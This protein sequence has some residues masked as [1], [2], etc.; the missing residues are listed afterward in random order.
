MF[1]VAEVLSG[2]ENKRFLHD[3]FK[4]RLSPQQL[5]DVTYPPASIGQQSARTRHANAMIIILS[6]YQS[7]G[8]P[9]FE[10]PS[11]SWVETQADNC[12]QAL[13][14]W[15]DLPNVRTLPASKDRAL[16]S[17]LY[18]ACAFVL[19]IAS[20]QLHWLYAFN[21]DLW[22]LVESKMEKHCSHCR[23]A[24]SHWT[25]ECRTMGGGV[26][27][28]QGPKRPYSETSEGRHP[29]DQGGQGSK[30]QPGNKKVGRS[31][32]EGGRFGNKKEQ[33]GKGGK[34]PRKGN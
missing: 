24:R 10:G 30:S 11:P 20:N 8:L 26:P 19:A 9:N 1:P 32:D 18:L 22:N 12:I 14:K 29:N 21:T 28:G 7:N 5:K 27:G 15:R 33:G 2:L 13:H 31:A 16:V 34:K 3:S 25:S 4:A 6:S 23:S 17:D